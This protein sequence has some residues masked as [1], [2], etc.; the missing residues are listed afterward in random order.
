MHKLLWTTGFNSRGFVRH[1]RRCT[2]HR[3][4]DFYRTVHD[5]CARTRPQLGTGRRR[6]QSGKSAVTGDVHRYG[7]PRTDLSVTLDGVT[8]KPALAL[9]GWV[10]FK[11]MHGEAMV[12]GDLVL[13]E[14][15]INPVMAQDD[16]GRPR[17]HRRAQ[18]SPALEP[19]H[20][21]YAC[22]RPRRSCQTRDR[23][24]RGA[25]RKQNPGGGASEHRANPA[26]AMDLDTTQLDQIMEA[27]GQAN[28][29]VYQFNVPRRDPVSMN[30]MTLTPACAARCRDRY[31]FSADRRRQGRHHR[32]LRPHQR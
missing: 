1:R 32:R 4:A 26:P 22:R 29:G 5:R 7:F 18:S 20:L 27:K 19:R 2:E 11:P 10:A 24:P 15:E 16:R 9:G 13:L 31:Q 17:H 14:S 25:G 3:L 21:L 28:G 12:M 6:F 8:I 23:H 30:G